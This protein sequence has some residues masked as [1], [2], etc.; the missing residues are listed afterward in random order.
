MIAFFKPAAPKALLAAE[1]IDSTYF[2]L[3]IQVFIS[4]FVGYAAYYFIRKN[5]SMAVPYLIET[6]G[7]SRTQVGFVASAFG[8]SYGISKFIMGLISDRCNPRYFMATGLILSGVVN[9]MFGFASSIAILFTL[10][11]LNGWFQG[12]GW[13]PCGRTM[14]HWFSNHERGF[15]MAIWNVSHNVGSSSVPILAITG[16]YIFN[17]WRGMFYFPAMLSILVGILVMIFLRDTPQS[18]GLMPIE[19]Y[20]NDHSPLSENIEDKEREMTSKE[21][22]FGH[23][24]NNKYIWLI[25]V[26]NL[27]VYLIRYGVLDW[28]PLYLKEA[29]GYDIK[30]AG[31]AFSLYEWLAIPGT[32]LIGWLSDKAFNGRRAPMAIICMIGVFIAIIVYWQCKSMLVINIAVA[33]IGFLIY[34]PVMLIGVAAIDSVPKKAAGTAAGFTGLFGYV[35]GVVLANLALGAIVDSYGWNGGFLFMLSSCLLAIICLLFTDGSDN[36]NTKNAKKIVV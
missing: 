18:V 17:T 34:G 4:I 23:V 13:P 20:R 1:K 15:K 3:R 30:S 5:Y 22:L 19:D 26:A 31:L 14:S 9:L 7:Y 25:A 2:R 28:I 24:L 12:M 6:Y 8:I 29:K 10:M 16:M 21:I 11:F 32:I 35:G 27:F 33:S 36:K